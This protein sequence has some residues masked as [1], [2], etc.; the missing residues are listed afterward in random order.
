[1]ML[2]DQGDCLVLLPGV[3]PGSSTVLGTQKV[4]RRYR[5][6]AKRTCLWALLAQE[7]VVGLVCTVHGLGSAHE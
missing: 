3:S 5:V 6:N 1:M 2:S 7:G 4:L